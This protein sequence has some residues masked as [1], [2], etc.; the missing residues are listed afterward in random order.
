MWLKG[1]YNYFKLT[2]MTFDLK[3][4]CTIGFRSEVLN[5]KGIIDK[6]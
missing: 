3:F 2:G 1:H 6:P 5:A 4:S